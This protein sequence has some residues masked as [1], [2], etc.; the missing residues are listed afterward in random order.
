MQ[1]KQ[2]IDLQISSTCFGQFFSHL[3]ERKSV[4]YSM[5]YNVLRLLSVGGMECSSNGYVFGVKD[6]A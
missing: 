6:A 4:N 3:Q 1:Q 2:F 5:W